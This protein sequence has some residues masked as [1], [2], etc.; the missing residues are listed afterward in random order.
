MLNGEAKRSEASDEETARQEDA[1]FAARGFEARYM[2]VVRGICGELSKLEPAVL[3]HISDLLRL[4]EDRQREPPAY[5]A[6][7]DNYERSSQLFFKLMNRTA[8]RVLSGTSLVFQAHDVAQTEVSTV[9]HALLEV[10]SRTS[11][12]KTRHYER[13]AARHRFLSAV[14][15]QLMQHVNAALSRWTP[16]AVTLCTR[17]CVAFPASSHMEDID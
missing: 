8:E 16:V 9:V 1:L 17:A 13:K 3:A 4:G 5:E 2:Q 11:R 7:C 6:L 14:A 10:A 15:S 12:Y